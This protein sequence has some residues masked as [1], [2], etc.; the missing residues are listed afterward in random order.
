M[1]FNLG[2]NED[3]IGNVNLVIQKILSPKY[4]N[5]M[6]FDCYNISNVKIYTAL[7]GCNFE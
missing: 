1:F 5:V 2:E 6:K 4:L 3:L 7:Y